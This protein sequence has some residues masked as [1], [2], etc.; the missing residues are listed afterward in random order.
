MIIIN[1]AID[2]LPMPRSEA[3][4]MHRAILVMIFMISGVPVFGQD[5]TSDPQPLVSKMGLADLERCG[6][7]AAVIEADR[8][9]VL[10]RNAQLM[11]R[12][13]SIG[14]EDKAIN[15]ARPT[16]DTRNPTAVAAFNKRVSANIQAIAAYN[17]DL[18]V[19]PAYVQAAKTHSNEF[20]VECAQRP[21]DQALLTQVSPAA[22]K[23][24]AKQS[25]TI[26]L[27]AVSV[28]TIPTPPAGVTS[29][30]S[31]GSAVLPGTTTILSR[32]TD[33]TRV[34]DLQAAAAAGDA[35]A[36][37]QL[38]LAYL[39]GRGVMRNREQAIGWL[40]KSAAGNNS[41]A[42]FALSEIYDSGNDPQDEKRSRA[43]LQQAAE[44]GNADAQHNL[45]IRYAGDRYGRPNLPV[46]IEWMTK[47]ATSG[48]PES[49]YVL[50]KFL[51]RGEGGRKEAAEALAWLQR[52]ADQGFRAAQQ[53]MGERYERGNGMPKDKVDAL[54]W[55]LLA[56]G[57][58]KVDAARSCTR[59]MG[60]S[61]EVREGSRK[62]ADDLIRA[63]PADA[64][65]TATRRADE[66]IVS[67]KA[68]K[69]GGC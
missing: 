14:A 27:P 51:Q 28:E 49:Q 61:R 21:Y 35:E 47:A 9:A 50:S 64:I 44:A 63:L 68:T 3:Q 2:K 52:S 30:A 18:T 31:T 29:F 5:A 56:A 26:D 34:A 11:A 62:A 25:S 60:N 58:T 16:I 10:R 48:D 43:Y 39:D 67:F 66:W 59:L 37:L 57:Q 15:A 24:L 33:A 42:M 13:K 55:Y 36:Q 45:G 32:P 53:L 20:N 1:E 65:E 7:L 22:R 19:K 46:A 38:G 6:S 69:V 41:K 40:E 8:E 4:S 12:A 17:R 23:A 54:K